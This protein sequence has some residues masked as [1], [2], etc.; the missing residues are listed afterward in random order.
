VT[1]ARSTA[2]HT[3]AA[4]SSAAVW[5]NLAVVYVVWGSTYVGIRLLVE[6]IPPL[7]GAAIRFL[8][9]GAAMLAFLAARGRTI[10]ARPRALAG[11]ALVGLL[12]PAGGNGLVTV[13]E[14]DVPSGLAALIVASIPLWVV[15][16]RATAGRERV[17]PATYG[18][19]ALG[20]AGL[21]VLLLPGSRP[22]AAGLGAMALLLLAAASWATGSF[23]TP[24]LALPADRL[25]SVAWQLVFGGIALAIGAVIAG[26]PSS[27]HAA[28]VSL[29]SWA[30]LAYLI[31]FGSWLAYSS[32]NWLLGNVPISKVATYAYVNPV[33]AVIL[34]FLVLGESIAA[35][36]LA[37]AALV[38]AA[39]V[40]IVRTEGRPMRSRAART[41][42]RARPASE[43]A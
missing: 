11:A 5:A 6:T 16:L 21:A 20:L 30:G 2:A 19:V 23:L 13:A 41:A 14:Q 42:S 39:V 8:V 9:A 31:S 4:P 32:Y 12:L 24:K 17:R 3:A 40:V 29:R 10:R 22:A 15:V 18:G 43:S 38:I 36:A 25:V 7:L 26:E 37:G 33:V 1:A 28:D 35:T 27:F 34:G